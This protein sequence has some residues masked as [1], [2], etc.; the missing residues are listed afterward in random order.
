MHRG[1]PLACHT[2][3]LHHDVGIGS[4][5]TLSLTNCCRW[6]IF[7]FII[8][9]V[10]CNSRI[11]SSFSRCGSRNSTAEYGRCTYGTALLTPRLALSGGLSH[12]KLSNPAR[13][14]GE[15]SPFIVASDHFLLQA[16]CVLC[17]SE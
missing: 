6:R 2:H 1:R 13:S 14:F 10:S 3:G 12:Q 9:F 7:S 4:L 8:T 17:N 5:L 16:V 11:V 15:A